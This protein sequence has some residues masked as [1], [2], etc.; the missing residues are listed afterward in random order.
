MPRILLPSFL[1]PISNNKSWATSLPINRSRWRSKGWETT[2]TRRE[3]FIT[4]MGQ[5]KV[6]IQLCP[7]PTNSTITTARMWYW[8]HNFTRSSR[9]R[10]FI[11]RNS[12]L[13]EHKNWAKHLQ[14]TQDTWTRTV[15][16]Q[17]SQKIWYKTLQLPKWLHLSTP[18]APKDLRLS[19][20]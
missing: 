1:W 19:N 4:I 14:L 12:M 20:R 16:C 10:R 5:P 7:E 3:V 17:T 9:P 6:K 13:W 2:S 11:Y 8:A 18:R 15:A